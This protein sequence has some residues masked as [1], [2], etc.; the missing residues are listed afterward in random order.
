M[1]ID[2]ARAAWPHI[3]TLLIGLHVVAVVALSLPTPYAVSS[4]RQWQTANMQ[5]DLEQWSKRLRFL[6]YESKQALEDDLWDLA[7]GYL[8]ARKTFIAPF[9]SYAEYTGARQGWRMF[10]NPRIEIA[11]LHIDIHDGEAWQP[12]Y[13]PF[14]DRYDFWADKFRHNRFRKLLGRISLPDMKGHYKQL[15]RFLAGAVARAYPEATSVRVR[16]YRYPSR[17]PADV[18]AGKE[19]AGRYDAALTFQAAG[20]R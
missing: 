14:S 6:G 12:V 17:P 15:A 8:S 18:R 20:V 1:D 3:R 4:R 10:A 5:N 19:P 9:E 2:K 7:Q 13:R 16:L 11:E